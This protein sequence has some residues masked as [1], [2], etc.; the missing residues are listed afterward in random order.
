MAYS[1]VK[2]WNLALAKVGGGTVESE[3]EDTRQRKAC[4][5]I[6]DQIRD[7][8]LET[9]V[10]GFAKGRVQLAET[11]ANPDFGWTY[12]YQLP[13][14]CLQPRR[15]ED[16]GAYDIEGDELLTESSPAQLHYTKSITD[17]AKVSPSF[18]ALFAHRMGIELAGSLTKNDQKRRDLIDEYAEVVDWHTGVEGAGDPG[19]TA[20]VSSY[21]SN[22]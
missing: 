22:R 1:K 10:W 8:I 2:L 5:A 14:D 3:S 18:A 15:L 12:S 6:H 20:N 21:E 7:E 9:H 16:D 19:R 17:M 13:V 4:S 11:S